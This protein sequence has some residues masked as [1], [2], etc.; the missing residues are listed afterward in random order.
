MNSRQHSNVSENNIDKQV[1]T[2]P[3]I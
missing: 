2:Y 3:C 1:I